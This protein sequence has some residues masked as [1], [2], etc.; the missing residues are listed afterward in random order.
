M[1]YGLYLCKPEYAYH[2]GDA[3]NL[4]LPFHII[5]AKFGSIWLNSLAEDYKKVIKCPE[6]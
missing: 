3:S 4:Q 1:S 6:S 2:N 5:H